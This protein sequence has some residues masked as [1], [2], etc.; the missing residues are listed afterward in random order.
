MEEMKK[1][2]TGAV[3]ATRV[4]RELLKGMSGGDTLTVELPDAAAIE[5]GKVTAYQLQ[6]LEGC[7]FSMSSDYVKRTLTIT[8][9]DL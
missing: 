3:K 2:M 4:T 8:R 5:S 6:R 7:K 9:T 1:K